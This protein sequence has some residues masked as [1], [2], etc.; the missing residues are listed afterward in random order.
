MSAAILSFPARHAHAVFIAKER[1]GQGWYA[2]AGSSGW[3][4]AS[5]SEARAV[6]R[7]LSRNLGVPVREM[8]A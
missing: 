3:L 1:E 8:P 2:L 6:A 5:L 7:W 4:C